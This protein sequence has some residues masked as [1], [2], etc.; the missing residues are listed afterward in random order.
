MAM[1]LKLR[2]E[3]DVGS[4][5]RSG[6]QSIKSVEISVQ[7]VPELPDFVQALKTLPD[8]WSR[9]HQGRL[10]CNICTAGPTR[11]SPGR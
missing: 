10:A 5:C 4:Q 3:C 9:D 11:L 8:G 1:F 2:F 6:G 7:I